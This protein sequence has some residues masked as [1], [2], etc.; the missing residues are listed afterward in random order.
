MKII[1][2]VPVLV[3][4]TALFLMAYAV[5]AAVGGETGGSQTPAKPPGDVAVPRKTPSPEELADRYRPGKPWDS[6]DP[7]LAEAR[8][9]DGYPLFWFG[10]SIRGYNLQRI[11]HVRYTTPWGDV[12]DEYSFICGTCKIEGRD[13]GCAVPASSACIPVCYVKPEHVAPAAR[14]R[15]PDGL[16]MGAETIQAGALMQRFAD[17]HV[18]I[19]TGKTMLDIGIIPEFGRVTDDDLAQLRGLGRNAFPQGGMLPAP[20][21]SG[22]PQQ[23][24]GS[25]KD[26]DALA[27]LLGRRS[28][29]RHSCSSRGP[30]GWLP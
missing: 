27:L 26:M 29:V 15:G 24:S 4:L 19:W 14:E 12:R 17:G 25:R 16:P 23:R 18:V 28:S 6:S 11:A 22:C 21:F 7:K 8:Q 3:A 20:D 1:G 10:P 13:G 2:A 30:R 9:F 5:I